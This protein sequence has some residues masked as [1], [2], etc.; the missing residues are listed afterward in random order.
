MFISE[1]MAAASEVAAS[2]PNAMTRML[3]QFGVIL[4]I[5]YLF[6]IRPQNKKMKAHQQMIAGVEKGDKAITSGGI[7]GKVVKVEEKEILLEIAEGVKIRVQKDK[8][9]HVGDFEKTDKLMAVTANSNDEAPVK[10]N[11][12]SDK[13]KEVLK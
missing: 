2:D 10:S 7:I 13:L 11:K 12:K 4:F 3:L 6:L 5:F 8:L 1:A 9:N